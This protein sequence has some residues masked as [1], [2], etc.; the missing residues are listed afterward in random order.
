M[1]K[2]KSV[3][4]YFALILISY[5]CVSWGKYGHELVGD[6]AKVYVNKPVMDSVQKY[7]GDMSWGDASTWMDEIR[8]DHFYDYLKPMH[9]VNV[10]EGQTYVKTPS[11]P[12]LTG[13]LC[14]RD[15]AYF[16]STVSAY[17]SNKTWYSLQKFLPLLL[18]CVKPQ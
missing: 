7:L 5:T 12:R 13:C 3:I 4:S 8:S 6:V 10:E 14:V 2:I 11:R 1:K 9:Y 16:T 17:N 18:Y 15:E